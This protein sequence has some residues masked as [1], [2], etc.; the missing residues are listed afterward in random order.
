[1]A[2]CICSIGFLIGII[3]IIPVCVNCSVASSY[4]SVCVYIAQG[5]CL[6]SESVQP[7]SIKV[8][9]WDAQQRQT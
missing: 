8:S 5:A 3:C 2:G 6:I 4:L 9:I 7:V 1:M